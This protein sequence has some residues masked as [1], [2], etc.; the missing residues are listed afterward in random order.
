MQLLQFVLSFKDLSQEI[1][2]ICDQRTKVL[3]FLLVLN[4]M[5]MLRNQINVYPNFYC[6][7][8]FYFC[9]IQLV[10]YVPTYQEKNCT[11]KFYI[12]S[13]FENISSHLCS[14]E[15]YCYPGKNLTTMK[16]FPKGVKFF[17]KGVK[18]FPKGVKFFPKGVK[19]FPKEWNFFHWIYVYL[20]LFTAN[21]AIWQLKRGGKFKRTIQLQIKLEFLYCNQL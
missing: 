8:D 10:R 16:F 1:L 9:Y 7:L 18:F 6:L 17:P 11:G 3:W 21:S 19:F 4:K 2:P 15:E 12:E 14:E 5:I 20:P 13:Y